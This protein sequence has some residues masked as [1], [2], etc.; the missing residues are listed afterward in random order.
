M[1]NLLIG[2]ALITLYGTQAN[3]ITFYNS[4][5]FKADYKFILTFSG[6]KGEER[7]ETFEFIKEKEETKEFSFREAFEHYKKEF[8][9]QSKLAIELWTGEYGAKCGTIEFTKT[10]EE[11]DKIRVQVDR[12]QKGGEPTCRIIP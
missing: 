5:P 7:E 1:K 12:P 6:P 11:L 2:I 9:E 10:P 4:E 8:G 3:A